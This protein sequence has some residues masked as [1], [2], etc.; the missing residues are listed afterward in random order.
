MKLGRSVAALAAAVVL[1][2][3]LVGLGFSAPFVIAWSVI[4]AAVAIP[5]FS[6]TTAKADL[7]NVKSDLHTL[8]IAEE[9]Y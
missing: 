1:G 2:L 6:N 8:V 4:L 5:K 7:A 9:G 3:V